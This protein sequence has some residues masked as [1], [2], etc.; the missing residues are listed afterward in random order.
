MIRVCLFVRFS[1]RFDSLTLLRMTQARIQRGR[2]WPAPLPS[3]AKKGGER[4]EKERKEEQKMEKRNIK[5]LRRHNL[6]FRAYI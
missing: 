6:F 3:S 2:S 5:K 1:H 4:E